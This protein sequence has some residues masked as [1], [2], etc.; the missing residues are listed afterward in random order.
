MTDQKRGLNK[1]PDIG[2]QGAYS[3][4]YGSNLMGATM[5]SGGTLGGSNVTG[6][7]GTM[8]T[9]TSATPAS[10]YGLGSHSSR[11]I[12]GHI[13]NC[14]FKALVTRF[15]KSL[16]EL[17]SQ[18][19]CRLYCNLRKFMTYVKEVHGGVFRRV[20]LSGILDSADRPNKRCNSNIQTTRVIR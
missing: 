13:F 11:G 4:N 19:N 3:T 8:T 16:K 15:V 12:E 7:T 6:V 14:V 20:V 5:V 10:M 18:E 1:S 9:N 2:T 17:K